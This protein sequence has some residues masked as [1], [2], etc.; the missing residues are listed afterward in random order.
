VA[1]LGGLRKFICSPS[2]SAEDLV[3]ALAAATLF[4][5]HP[6]HVEVVAWISSRKDLVAT[7][8]A[9][10][11]M[12]STCAGGAERRP[13]TR[14]LAGPASAGT[15]AAS[16]RSLAASAAKQSVLLLPVVMF[17]WDLLVE[18][19]RDWRMVAD[20]LPFGVITLFFGWMTWHAQPSTNQAASAFVIGSTELTNLWLLTGLGQYTLYRTAPNR[21]AGVWQPVSRSSPP[22]SWSG[23]CRSSGCACANRSARSWVIGF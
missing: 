20:K 4:L 8:F 17:G 1:W 13:P 23:R 2:P 11:S 5:L 14:L 12:T 15:S 19:R 18:R 9:V 6:A 10:L 22:P 7:C 16:S 3:I 21:L